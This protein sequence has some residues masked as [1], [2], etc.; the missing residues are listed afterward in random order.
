MESYLLTLFTSL[1]QLFKRAQQE[2]ITLTDNGN[3]FFKHYQRLCEEMLFF[4]AYPP[5]TELAELAKQTDEPSF[6][7]H[8][9]DNL[10]LLI[11]SPLYSL[12]SFARHGVSSSYRSATKIELTYFCL[13][14]DGSKRTLISALFLDRV[15]TQLLRARAH[16]FPRI[17]TRKEVKAALNKAINYTVSELRRYQD[18]N[19]MRY[20]VRLARSIFDRNNQ[21]SPVQYLKTIPLKEIHYS[22]YCLD[23]LEFALYTLLH[24]DDETAL[25]AFIAQQNSSMVIA[26]YWSLLVFHLAYG[27]V[28]THPLNSINYQIETALDC[29]FSNTYLT[30][31]NE[32]K[33]VLTYY[34]NPKVKHLLENEKHRLGLK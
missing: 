30:K 16:V 6:V 5:Q 14:Y 23:S 32:Y 33:S 25:F 18:N 13:K 11:R 7:H 26:N 8:F 3:S 10:S 12:F 1:D 20:F 15:I 22:N 28:T 24:Y 29:G 31:L 9:N 4:S 27:F 21:T 2:N 34:A 17:L 19:E